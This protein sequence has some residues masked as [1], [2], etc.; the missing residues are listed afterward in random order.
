[1]KMQITMIAFIILTFL[2]CEE[3][4][5]ANLTNIQEQ[6]SIG[7]VVEIVTTTNNSITA[8]TAVGS[9]ATTLEY[10]DGENGTLLENMKVFVLF[11]DNSE[12][13]GDTS[14][15]LIDQEVLVNTVTLNDFTEGVNGFPI[16]D[17]TISAL[18]FL[19]FTDNTSESIAPN[20]T[21]TTRFELLLTDGRVFTNTNTGDNGGLNSDF[22]I[23]TQ[24]E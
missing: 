6:A 20:D 13:E 14:N 23:N 1:M 7:A 16:F 18:E 17:L 19:A 12:N 4:D 2:S 5:N 3:D 22:T 21:F 9:L 10:R 15:A 8:G 11:L 24:V